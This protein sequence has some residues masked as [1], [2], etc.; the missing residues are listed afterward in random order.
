MGIK[1]RPFYF[2]FCDSCKVCLEENNLI[3]VEEKIGQLQE[4]AKDEYGWKR[5]KGRWLCPDCQLE[6]RT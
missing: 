6:E 4:I 3:L 5:V 2:L 1:Q